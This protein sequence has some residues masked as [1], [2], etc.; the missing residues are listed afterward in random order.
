MIGN[1]IL[2]VISQKYMLEIQG[3][4]ETKKMVVENCFIKDTSWEYEKEWRLVAKPTQL[5]VIL[6]DRGKYALNLAN[7]ITGVYLGAKVNEARKQQVCNHFKGTKVEVYQM[8]MQSDSYT[9]VP[10]LI[11]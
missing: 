3:D 11:E 6:G 4:A 10:M 7:Y 2:N 9:L 1:F 5:S 8:Q